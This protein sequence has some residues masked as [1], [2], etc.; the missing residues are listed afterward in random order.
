[1]LNKVK[2]LWIIL[3]IPALALADQPAEERM[4][5]TIRDCIVMALE[6]NLEISIERLTPQMDAADILK[7][8]GDFDPALVFTPN[9]L[10]EESPLTAQAA[11]AAG[12]RA[13]TQTRT[14][15]V[16]TSV[17]GK[18]PLG[19]E[20][21]LNLTSADTQSTFNS[22]RDQY[23]TF[24][25]LELTQP[26]LKGFG[27]ANQLN[28][29]RIARKQKEISEEAL[30]QKV[31][32]IVT[33]IKSAYYNLFF[34]LENQRVQFQALEEATKLLENNRKRVEIGVLTPLDV[35]TAES[36]VA[37]REVQ[38]ISTNQE[39]KQRMNELRALIFEDISG[40]R[41]RMLWPMDQPSDIPVP[42]R[43]LDEVFANA[44]EDRP[45][46][47]QA[48]LAVEQQ[49]L[50]VKYYENQG[51][52]QVDLKGSYGYNGIGNDFSESVT[53]E[54]RRWAL[55]FAVRIPLPDQ[56][57]QG[58]LEKSRLERARALL[59]L[60]QAEQTVLLEVDNAWEKVQTN[61]KSI[62]ATRVATHAAEEALAAE[63][64]KLKAGTTTSFTVLQMQNKAADARSREIRAL[65]DYNISLAELEK[66]EGISLR[67][68]QIELVK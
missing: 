17:E 28:T 48:K 12:G 50:Q 60:K 29:I 49:H 6:N 45:D 51:Y 23:D 58:Q 47:R 35:A 57:G 65:A 22:F 7:A 16:D 9:Y 19:T 52:P 2:H 15:S 34:A 21:K 5:L 26:L 54:D 27:P 1:M 68:N 62:L 46:Y 67:K 25:G 59:Q 32:D 31:A 43:N 39:V 8:R 3:V 37:E 24:W 11:V 56:T 38:V 44:M 33:R 42:S 53:T 10:Y 41:D 36:G 63:M 18:I 20:Y 30:T 14:A 13:A 40:V 55:G 64:T 4:P 66:A 61:Y